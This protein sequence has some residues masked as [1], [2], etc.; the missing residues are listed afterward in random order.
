[1]SK[2][3]SPEEHYLR[4]LQLYIPWRNESELKQVHQ[5]YKDRYKEIEA[6]I[7]HNIKKHELYLDIDY[8]ELQNF[9][10]VQSLEEFSMK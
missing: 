6:D 9:S 8:E 5:C 10:F 2:L 3:K 4:L 1:M 7:L